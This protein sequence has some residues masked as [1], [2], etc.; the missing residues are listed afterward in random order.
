MKQQNHEIW[1]IIVVLFLFSMSMGYFESSIVIY[2]REIYYPDGFG[3]PLREMDMDMFTVE[4]FREFFSLVMLVTVAL[5]VS[6]KLKNWFAWFIFAFAWWDIFYYIFL[7]IFLDWPESLFTWD[8]LFLLPV[9]W[10]G[11]VIAPVI[12]SATMIVLAAII[13]FAGKS[14]SHKGPSAYEWSLLIVGALITTIGYTFDYSSHILDN[15]GFIE[16][17]KSIN[18]DE[19]LS[20]SLAYVP[21]RFPWI[22]FISG[23]LYFLLAIISIARRNSLPE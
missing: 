21:R 12:N 23:Q 10:T 8:I 22:L 17:L 13:V 14:D 20:H 6:R 19:L 7:K 16:M 2:L 3:F 11:P 4:I 18:T 5:L 1:T 15:Y 9:T